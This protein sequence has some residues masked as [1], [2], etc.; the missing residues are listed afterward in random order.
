MT[1]WSLGTIPTSG[2]P[3]FPS[4]RLSLKGFL[5]KKKQSPQPGVH[6]RLP[7][8]KL[9]TCVNSLRSRL[10][11]VSEKDQLVEARNIGKRPMAMASSL[12]RESVLGGFWLLQLFLLFVCWPPLFLWFFLMKLWEF[13]AS[14]EANGC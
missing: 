7:G 1:N 2:G 10:G 11:Q 3:H 9:K 6:G 5:C 13:G 4:E 14:C 12:A 8:W